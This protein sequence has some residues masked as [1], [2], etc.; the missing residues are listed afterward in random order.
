MAQSSRFW[1]FIAKRY[2]RSPV[3]DE[4]AYQKKLEITRGYLRPDMEMLEFGCGTGSTAIVHAPYV[5]HIRATDL[6][7]KMLDIA[8]AKADAAGITN[9]TFERVDID[10]LDGG[11]GTYDIVLG[12]S[13]LHLVQ[14]KEAVIGKVHRMLKPNGI[15]VSSTACL[16]ETM[17]FLKY[18]GPIG[19]AL[20]LLPLV[21]VF[22]VPELVDSLTHGGFVIEHQW[23]PGKGKAV[24]IVARKANA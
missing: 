14:D 6:S 11:D 21:K 12:M 4:A 17:A 9:I 3:A 8:R 22:T 24:F 19:S 7:K 18:I 2:A 23:Q 10:E 16:G 5:R 20:G 1:D 13:I 15:F